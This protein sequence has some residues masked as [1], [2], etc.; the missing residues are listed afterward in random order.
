MPGKIVLLSF[1]IPLVGA[2]TVYPWIFVSLSSWRD[3]TET[4]LS[5]LEMHEQTHIRQQGRWYAWAWVLGLLAW[6][7]CYCLLLP[8]G[9]NPFRRRWEREA[10][11]DGQGLTTEQADVILRGAP[12]WL[13]W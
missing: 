6:W 4:V 1:N 3:E 11:A 8:I 13:V 2:I 5:A 9:W 10:C 7:F 12:Y